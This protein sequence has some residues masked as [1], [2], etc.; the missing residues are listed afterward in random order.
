MKKMLFLITWLWLTICFELRTNEQK[1]ITL[2]FIV[3]LFA[4]DGV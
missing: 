2:D 4:L 3:C 1:I